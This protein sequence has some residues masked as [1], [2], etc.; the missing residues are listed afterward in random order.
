[1][2][3][4]SAFNGETETTCV[5]GE[6]APSI[7]LRNSR[8]MQTRNAA[9]VFPEP[10]GAEMSVGLP[11]STLGHPCTC[12]SVGVENRVTNHSATM[13]CAQEISG[14]KPM[15]AIVASSPFLC[16]KRSLDTN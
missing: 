16:Q 1:M 15:R 14:G 10:V 9:R 11:L 13:G 12:G 4:D 2:S 5:S 6:R 7:A 3:L 8:S